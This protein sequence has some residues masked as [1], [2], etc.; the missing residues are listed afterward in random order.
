ME[1]QFR[2]RWIKKLRILTMGL[3]FSSALNI[4][5]I[6]TLLVSLW[7]D[8]AMP[9]GYL[10]EEKEEVT[11]SNAELLKTY[12]K[13]SFREL[14]ALLTNADVVEEGYRKRDLALSALVSFHHFNLEK[15]LGGMPEQR[16]VLQRGNERTVFLFP[17]LRDEEFQAVIRFAYLEKWPLTGEGLF[18]LLQ[19]QGMRDP[20]LV[21]T[22]ALTPEF[23]ALR[24]VLKVEPNALIDLAIEGTW[25]MLDSLVKEQSQMMDLSDDRRRHILLSYLAN[26]SG[27]AARLLI[28]T[29]FQFAL[30]KLDDKGILDLLKH[31]SHER[32][33]SLKKFCTGLLQSPRSDVVWAKA[34]E[35]LGGEAPPMPVV[36]QPVQEVARKIAAPKAEVVLSKKTH[37][38]QEGENLWKIARQYKISVEELVAQNGLEKDRIRTGMVLQIPSSH[39]TGSLPPG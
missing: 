37:I 24:S 15:A 14:S 33:E 19:N 2:E 5:L 6:A 27:T 11:F 12:E 20:T 10:R 17:S 9:L 21:Q 28:E 23:C 39:G 8:P 7:Q 16:R 29:D 35:L 38:V 36:P 22:F 31:Q 4:G 13:I 1:S 18:A 25:A 32:S 30:K 3:I 34:R 26:E